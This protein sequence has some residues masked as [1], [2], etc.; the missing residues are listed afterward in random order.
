MVQTI[1]SSIKKITW[2]KKYELGVPLIDSQHRRL[3]EIAG[4]LYDTLSGDPSQYQSNLSKILKDLADYTEYHFSTEEN[5]LSE[6]SYTGLESHKIA[7]KNFIMELNN[8]IRKLYSSSN[9]N[10]LPQYGSTCNTCDFK[11]VCTLISSGLRFYDY[12]LSWLL[13][14]IAKADRLWFEFMKNKESISKGITI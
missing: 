8:Q 7:H 14:H 1:N 9:R 13:T 2:E 3:V 5:M 12:V 11:D 4:D 10:D 6:M